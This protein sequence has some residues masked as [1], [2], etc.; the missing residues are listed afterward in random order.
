MGFYGFIYIKINDFKSEKENFKKI[1]GNLQ[2][3]SLKNFVFS[4]FTKKTILKKSFQVFSSA[5][6]SFNFAPEDLT[7]DKGVI[8]KTIVPGT[9]SKIIGNPKV[10][11]HYEGALESGFVFDSS[12]QRKEPYTFILGEKKVIKGWEIGVSS[13]KIGEKSKF[14][15]SSEYGYKKKGIPPLIPPNAKLFFTIEL[16]EVFSDN[17]S[18]K[19]FYSDNKN[20]SL[21]NSASISELSSREIKTNNSGDKNDFFKKFFFISP[22]M[23][24]TGREAPWWLNPNITFVLVFLIMALVFWFV[25]SLG[26]IHQGYVQ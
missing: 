2:K 1:S 23:S 4:Y 15:I 14:E 21:K 13:M 22:F 24:Q 11:V 26:G 6:E 3:P 20:L 25:L 12:Y 16:L 10:T 17:L 8:K 5:S 7:G 19:S 18:T 9:G